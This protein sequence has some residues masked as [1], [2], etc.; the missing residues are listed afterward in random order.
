M[1]GPWAP[2]LA[3]T[4]GSDAANVALYTQG[5]ANDFIVG[6][7]STAVDQLGVTPGQASGALAALREAALPGI[8]QLSTGTSATGRAW[9]QAGQSGDP[10]TFGDEAHW[11]LGVR[12]RLA[13]LSDGTNRYNVRIGW[14][15]SQSDVD[16]V[17]G[18]YFKYQD[19]LN[20]G[21]WTLN[22]YNGALTTTNST[23]AAATGWHTYLIDCPLGS[24]P[25]FYI[26]GVRAGTVT[27]YPTIAN[28]HHTALMPAKICKSLG[29]TARTLD[30]DWY[31][32][33]W[34][35]L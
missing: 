7:L 27:G 29:L 33:T 16:N 32:L 31:Y 1:N 30:V 18:L 22:A 23:I 11:S 10:F 35:R 25:V 15:I 13:A 28:A 20:G 4:P 6:S 34:A 17:D 21:S 2:P 5:W 9:L 8:I 24:D 26:D 3:P 12:A 19:S 14:N